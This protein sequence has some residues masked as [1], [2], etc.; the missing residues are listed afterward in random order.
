MTEEEIACYALEPMR[1]SSKSKKVNEGGSIKPDS[2]TRE[3]LKRMRRKDIKRRVK[4]SSTIL[5]GS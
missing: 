1:L 2:L 4:E 5:I 3:I